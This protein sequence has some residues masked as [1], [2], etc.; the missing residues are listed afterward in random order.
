MLRVEHEAVVLIE[1]GEAEARLRGRRRGGGFDGRTHLVVRIQLLRILEEREQRRDQGVDAGHDANRN[2]APPPGRTTRGS[3]KAHE[4]G[5]SNRQE[6]TGQHEYV[7][8]P[9]V[10][11]RGLGVERSERCH[12]HA[13]LGDAHEL[14]LSEAFRLRGLVTEVP[15]DQFDRRE[16]RSRSAL[17][18]RR[19]RPGVIN[20]RVRSADAGRRRLGIL[21]VFEILPGRGIT[22]EGAHR[23]TRHQAWPKRR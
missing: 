11:S 17:E 9:F 13:E 15:L 12:L 3:R 19:R 7:I 1:L 16:P 21:F 4:C 20:R 5:D 18:T 22:S 23:Q 2:L 8:P 10:V 6:D 14:P